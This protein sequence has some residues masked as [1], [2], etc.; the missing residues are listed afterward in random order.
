MSD[1]EP[2]DEI[3]YDL[4]EALD[5][6]AALETASETMRDTERLAGVMLLEGQ[7][8]VLHRKLRLDDGGTDAG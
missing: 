2:P 1:A 4:E 8:L 7:I 5:L 6:L 3:V